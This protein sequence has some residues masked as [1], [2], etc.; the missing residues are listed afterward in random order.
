MCGIAGIIAPSLSVDSI[1]HM[2]RCMSDAIVHRG[3]DGHGEWFDNRAPLALVHRRL[4]IQDLSPAGHQPM[5]SS[6]GRYQIVFNGEIYNFKELASE[7]EKAGFRFRGGSDTEVMLAAFECWGVEPA[8]K[9][10]T[11]MFAFAL[12]D[13]SDKTLLLCRDRIGEKP[14]YYGWARGG[15]VFASELKSIY[16]VVGEHLKVDDSALAAY[17]RFG[18]V[19]SPHSIYSGIY[20]LVPGTTLTID[21]A[22]S[23]GGEGFCPYADSSLFAPKKYWSVLTVAHEGIERPVRDEAQ[24]I[25]ELDGLLRT[26]IGNQCIADVP[27]GAFLSGGIDS[28]LVASIM[29]AVNDRPINTFTIGFSEKEFDEAPYAKKISQHLGTSHHEFYISANDCLQLIPQLPVIWDEPFA[30]ASQMPAL[31]VARLARTKVTVCLSGD[32]GDEIFCGYN[33]YISTQQFWSKFGNIPRPLRTLLGKSMAMASPAVWDNLYKFAMQ[34][35]NDSRTQANVGVK[36]HKLAEILQLNSINEVYRYL[37]SYWNDTSHL[38]AATEAPS[39]M[40]RAPDPGLH[41]FINNAML[42]D[43]LGYLPDDNLVKG[44]RSSMA[45]GMEFRLPLLDHKVIEYSW[46]LPLEMKNKQGVSKSILRQLLYRYVPRELIER[47]KMGFS[48]PI[49]AWLKGPLRDW[50]E[51]LLV[52][53]ALESS[54]LSAARIRAGWK[55]HCSGTKDHSNQLWT[56]LMYRMWRNN[57]SAQRL[58]TPE[59]EVSVTSRL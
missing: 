7:L 2:A 25:T 5:S 41:H 42:W 16:S 19:P 23:F 21:V 48:V 59:K 33:R 43:Q 11:G 12:Y 4:A 39:V 45:V 51:S 57:L 30:D 14:L 52:K 18:Y 22:N 36:V 44:D 6:S 28:T 32:G 1:K 17:L 34:L 9:R 8:I 49:G 20:K 53:E 26:A 10:F 46:R 13:S 54:G 38:L 35:K 37:L 15:F 55:E 47:P 58:F 40:D 31:L 3:P 56:I 24:A 27:I 50:A 29:Q